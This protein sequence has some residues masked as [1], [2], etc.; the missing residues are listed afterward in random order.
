MSCL[1]LHFYWQSSIW[2]FNMQ[3]N[4]WFGPDWVGPS[5][6]YFKKWIYTPKKWSAWS[7]IGSTRDKKTMLNIANECNS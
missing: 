1:E 3:T 7:K 4:N 6:G 5:L 2:Q